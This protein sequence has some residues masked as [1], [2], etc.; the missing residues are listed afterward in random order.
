MK[1]VILT[2]QESEASVYKKEKVQHTQHH[3]KLPTHPQ[4]ILVDMNFRAVVPD[5]TRQSIET[6]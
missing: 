4:C 6:F 2:V 3:C 1:Y 5:R